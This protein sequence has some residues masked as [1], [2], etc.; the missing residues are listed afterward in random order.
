MFKAQGSG[1]TDEAVQQIVGNTKKVCVGDKEEF[2]IAVTLLITSISQ[3]TRKL[4][5]SC[6]SSV[7]ACFLV[8]GIFGGVVRLAFSNPD[9]I[10]NRNM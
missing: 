3:G 5:I 4:W 8:F 1:C 10:L 9:P 2:C 7:S 6:V